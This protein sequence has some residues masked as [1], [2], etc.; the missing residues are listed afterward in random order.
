MLS[1][2]E[3]DGEFVWNESEIITTDDAITEDTYTAF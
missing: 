2:K 1:E 3:D